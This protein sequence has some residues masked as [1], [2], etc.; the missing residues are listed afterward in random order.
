LSFLA[1][2]RFGLEG[3]EA[4]IPGMKALIDA[5]AD[6]GVESVVIGMPHRGG[7]VLGG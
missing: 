3:C 5:A 1:L 4:L 2:R 7:S 6:R